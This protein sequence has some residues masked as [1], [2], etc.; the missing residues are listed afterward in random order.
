[1]IELNVP[2]SSTRSHVTQQTRVQMEKLY[3]WETIAVY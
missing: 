3:D 1:M 2:N